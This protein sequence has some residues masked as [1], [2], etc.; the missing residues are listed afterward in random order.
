MAAMLTDRKIH[1]EDVK[2]KPEWVG[3]LTALV[4]DGTIGLRTA[5]ELIIMM[6]DTNKEPDTL[7]EEKGLKQVSD[8]GE[9]EK[10][11]DSII[12]ANPNEVAGYKAG[13]EKLMGFFVGQVMKATAGKANPGIINKLL[14]DKLSK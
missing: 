2:V 5:K 12:E 7:I 13:K 1:I 4:D 14:K 9:I 11:I 6:E 3:R 8:T 10:I